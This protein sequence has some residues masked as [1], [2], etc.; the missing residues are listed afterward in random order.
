MLTNNSTNSIQNKT[1]AIEAEHLK[2]NITNNNDQSKM[3]VQ[4]LNCELY[5]SVSYHQAHC[6]MWQ[7]RPADCRDVPKGKTNA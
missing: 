4:L 2:H 6:S 3:L 1:K 7:D 5:L